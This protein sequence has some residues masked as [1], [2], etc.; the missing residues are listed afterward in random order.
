MMMP[1]ADPDMEVVQALI[2]AFVRRDADAMLALTHPDAEWVNPEYAI[3]PGV[4]RGH[5]E[6]RRAIERLFEFFHSVEVE[7]MERTP[8]GRILVDSRVRSGGT[9]GGPGLESRTGT[10]YTVRDGILRRY[11]WFLSAT[12]AR[13]A[14]GMQ[15]G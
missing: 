13:A 4:R 2:D 15:G 14:A 10:L 6:I 5:E 7:S 12:E 3:E 8:D 9:G 1:V 11:E